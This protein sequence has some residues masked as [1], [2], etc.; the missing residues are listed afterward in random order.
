MV[1][2]GLR[3]FIVFSPVRIKY[4]FK[5]G[6]GFNPKGGERFPEYAVS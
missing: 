6:A 4:F 2:G 3:L 5:V 1:S